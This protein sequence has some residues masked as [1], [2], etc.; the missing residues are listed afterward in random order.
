[1]TK[2]R[3]RGESL[4]E[5]V[6]TIMIISVAVA[7]LVASLASASRSSLTHRRAQ[8]TDVVVRDYAEAM[9]L[10]TSA[11]VA[12]APYSLTYT[13][14]SGY[15]LTG[16]ADDGLFDGRSGICPAVSTVQ[17]VTLSVEANGSAPAS[18]QLAVR[19]P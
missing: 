3:D 14:P 16:S 10:S 5:V 8:D 17:V 13:P 2:M 19:T 7:A 12:A 6:I 9:K 18:I 11:C 15:T 4:I 1:M